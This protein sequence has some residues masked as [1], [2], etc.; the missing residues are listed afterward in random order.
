MWER[1]W[2]EFSRSLIKLF[3]Y[4]FSMFKNTAPKHSGSKEVKSLGDAVPSA[5]FDGFEKELEKGKSKSLSLSHQ[6]KQPDTPDNSAS[7]SSRFSL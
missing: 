5:S 2:E 1:L 6:N 3:E 4:L 7:T